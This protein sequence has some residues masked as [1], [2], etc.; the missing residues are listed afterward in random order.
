MV[1]TMKT[2]VI[3]VEDEEFTIRRYSVIEKIEAA[4]KASIDKLNKMSLE[5]QYDL[6]R[7]M[8]AANT[9]LDAESLKEY[10]NVQL[11]LVFLEIWKFNKIPLESNKQLNTQSSEARTSS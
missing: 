5:Q 8:V 6:T 11:D 10:D 2:K 7:V 1:R 9:G 4:K 3:K